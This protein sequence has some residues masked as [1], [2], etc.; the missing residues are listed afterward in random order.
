MPKSSFKPRVLALMILSAAIALLAAILLLSSCTS[1]QSSSGSTGS[2]SGGS[3]E[4]AAQTEAPSEQTE[5]EFDTSGFIGTWHLVD[6]EQDGLRVSE[7]NPDVVPE[8]Y[9]SD[10]F[11]INEDGSFAL[12]QGERVT[13]GTWKATS[14]SEGVFI[15]GTYKEPFSISDGVLV[16]VTGETTGYYALGET[17]ETPSS[18][19]NAGESAQASDPE[20]AATAGAS[21]QGRV[22]SSAF[23][24]TWYLADMVKDG[25]RASEVNPDG[26]AGYADSYYLNLDEDGFF[27]FVQNG[28]V[29]QGVWTASAPTEGLAV[30]GIDDVPM[31]IV[32][33]VLELGSEKSGSIMYFAKGEYREPPELPEG[34]TDLRVVLGY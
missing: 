7:A 27:E 13:Q 20:S 21:A 26:L 3:Q 5:P 11:N 8:M 31:A 23:V 22:D 18:S 33:D 14:P 16:F 19:N 2:T 10:Y 32:D 1:G 29:Y 12:V 6:L 25:Q 24:G 4:S 30:V 28:E 9:E 15:I 34:Q 17:Y